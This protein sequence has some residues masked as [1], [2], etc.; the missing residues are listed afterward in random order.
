MAVAQPNRE[1]LY[2]TLTTPDIFVDRALS[3][4]PKSPE[5][6]GFHYNRELLRAAMANTYLETVGDRA[7][8]IHLAIRRVPMSAVLDA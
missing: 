5:L 2:R 8:S 7:D 6:A 1:K 4:R 3:L